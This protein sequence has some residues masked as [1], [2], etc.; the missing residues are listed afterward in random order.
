MG[1]V[2]AGDVHYVEFVTSDAQATR[3]FLEKTHGWRFHEVA[4][5]GGSFVAVLP[6]GTRV[7]VRGSMHEM[8]KPLTRAYV[9]VPDVEAAV[10]RAEEL[11]AEVGLPMMELPGHGRIAIYFL[12]GVEHGVW[13][14]P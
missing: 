10:K 3:A 14:T 4:E 1:F 7:G 8:E 11:G 9:R 12:G 5:L 13:E 2:D 6:N